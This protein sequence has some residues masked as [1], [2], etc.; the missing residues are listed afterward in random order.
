[1]GELLVS[2][3]VINQAPL[4]KKTPS[5]R[6]KGLCFFLKALLR[7]TNRVG[8]L[9]LIPGIFQKLEFPPQNQTNCWNWTNEMYIQK[10]VNK[11]KWHIKR[12][13]YSCWYLSVFKNVEI[14]SY[15]Q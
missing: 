10:S 7:E 5:L 13:A 15:V 11:K 2:R 1:M 3:R 9:A 8:W 14:Q 12:L 4:T 6:N